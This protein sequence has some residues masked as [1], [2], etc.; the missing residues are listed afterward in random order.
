MDNQFDKFLSKVESKKIP[1]WAHLD[2]TYRCNAACI[3]CYCQDLPDEWSGPELTT[4]EVFNLLEQLSEI[5]SLYLILSGG[6]VLLRKD[7]FQIANYARHLHFALTIFSNGL[8]IDEDKA[9]RLAELTPLAI[10]ISIYGAD[11][12]IHDAITQ[13]PGSFEQVI[14]AVKLLKERNLWVVLKTTLMKSNFHQADMI[15]KLSSNLGADDYRFNLEIS[16]KNDGNKTVQKY[17]IDKWQLEEFVTHQLK[18]ETIPEICYQEA[19]QKPLCGAGTIGCYI[20]PTG[21]TYPCA[22]LLRPMGNIKNQTFHEIWYG[23]SEIRHELTG[24]NTYADLAE[25]R[26]CYYVKT[27]QRCN[28]MAD[29][30]TGDLK[31][32]YPTLKHLSRIHYELVNAKE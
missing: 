21:N 17:Q 9:N 20:A 26:S 15:K 3:H 10:E 25:C 23:D 8:L 32:C 27:C 14:K 2:L 31:K 6:E 19:N 12:S 1:L 22:Q 30:E 4:N 11:A 5:G 13:K 16:P 29:L 24:L 7:F 28:G 18:Q